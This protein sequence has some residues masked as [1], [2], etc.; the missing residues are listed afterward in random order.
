MKNILSVIVCLVIV[1]FAQAQKDVI[2][3]HDAK[4]LQTA[5]SSAVPGITIEMYSVNFVGKFKVPAG[6]N[7]TQDKPITLI[8][9]GQTVLETG[10]KKFGYGLALQGNSYWHLK[11]FTVTNCKKGIVLD[12][13]SN[14]IIEQI[15]INNI[16]EEA[17]HFRTFSCHNI[18]KGC[19]ITNTGLLSPG[20]GEACYIGSAINNW[21]RYTDGKPDTCNYNI[22]EQNTFGPGVAAEGVDVKEGTSYNIIRNNIFYGKGEKGENSGDSWMEIKGNHTLIQG[23]HGYDGLRDGFQVTIKAEGW[24][25]YNTFSNNICE[26]NG[27]G[28]GIRIQLKDGTANGNIVYDNNVVKGAAEGVSN[29]EV[30]KMN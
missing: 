4:E 3:V 6:V 17:I 9:T 14:N 16:S 5:L 19:H 26:V 23:N 13:S 10:D 18:L 12:R 22:I 29:V 8:G 15:N 24:G 1:L 20:Y 25:A 30:T 27:P 21:D 28:L 2:R 11:N 7:G